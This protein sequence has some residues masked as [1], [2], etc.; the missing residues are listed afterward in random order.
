[1]SDDAFENEI[2]LYTSSNPHT[3]THAHAHA[4]MRRDETIKRKGEYAKKG[5]HPR[6]NHIYL[7]TMNRI[8]KFIHILLNFNES[9]EIAKL[10]KS[11]V[12]PYNNICMR[13]ASTRFHTADIGETPT[14]LPNRAANAE[15]A[16]F[17]P[18]YWKINT[19][20]KNSL[21]HAGRQW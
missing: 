21:A 9:R 8:Y 5:T 1:M 2:N 3:H 16:P 15:N 6:R 19:H 10:L 12:T 17:V 11:I 20:T 13:F 4:A 7:I 18:I 14:Y